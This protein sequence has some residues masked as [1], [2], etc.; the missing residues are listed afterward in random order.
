MRAAAAAG[1]SGGW[2]PCRVDV[3]REAPA[4][5]GGGWRSRD[6]EAASACDRPRHNCILLVERNNLENRHCQEEVSQSETTGLC[7]RHPGDRRRTGNQNA[8]GTGGRSD[9]SLIFE[10]TPSS[11]F[12]TAR[13]ERQRE[14]ERQGL[15]ARRAHVDAGTTT[16]DGGRRDRFFQVLPEKR[17][18]AK[19]ACRSASCATQRARLRACATC[20]NTSTKN[21][22]LRLHRN[23]RL[24]TKQ[25]AGAGCLDSHAH[26]CA[27]KTSEQRR[28]ERLQAA[29]I[30]NCGT[31]AKSTKVQEAAVSRRQKSHKLGVKIGGFVQRAVC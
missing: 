18:R 21:W 8:T 16:Q 6:R 22:G 23:R 31:R 5:V 9:F 10:R 11:R 3:S 14:T 19:I 29:W 2:A 13:P 12:R 25:L 1:C 15:R 27:H 20:T 7:G 28:R 4:T 26:R 30:P 24:S 17:K